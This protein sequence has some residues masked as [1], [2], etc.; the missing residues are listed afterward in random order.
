MFNIATLGL[1]TT[2]MGWV[3]IIIA[4]RYAI[5]QVVVDIAAEAGA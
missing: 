3:A 1:Y 5:S 4:V 2:Q